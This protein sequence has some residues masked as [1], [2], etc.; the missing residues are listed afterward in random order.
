MTTKPSYQ[1]AVQRPTLRHRLQ[2]LASGPAAEPETS[3]QN[4]GRYFAGEDIP[5][6]VVEEIQGRI[7]TALTA[8]G[9][10][11]G[12]YRFDRTKSILHLWSAV[13]ISDRRCYH[14]RRAPCRGSRP[15]PHPGQYGSGPRR[16]SPGIPLLARESVVHAPVHRALP[17]QGDQALPVPP[18]ATDIALCCHP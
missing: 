16:V 3:G 2:G 8:T 17:V 5:A 18:H 15:A 6:K 1:H 14:R 4:P 12:V 13:G 9:L 11:D 10:F 7:A